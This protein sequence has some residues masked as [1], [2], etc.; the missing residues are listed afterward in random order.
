MSRDTQDNSKMDITEKESFLR[1]RFD[2]L[3]DNSQTTLLDLQST[4]ASVVHCVILH[5]LF[6]GGMIAQQGLRATY[7]MTDSVHSCTGCEDPM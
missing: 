4:R 1:A 3:Y 6:L 7:R 5:I 2:F